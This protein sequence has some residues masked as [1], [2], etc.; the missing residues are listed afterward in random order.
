MFD[1]LFN[2]VFVDA[3]VRATIPI[4]LAALGGAIAERAGVFQIALE[5]SILVGAF[6]GIA[7]SYWTENAWVGLLFG[8]I[9]G[10]LVASVLAFGAVLRKADPIVLGIAINL[11]AV[12]VTGF[13]LTQ[14]FGVRGQFRSPRI[15]GLN[16]IEI[17]LL[18]EIPVIG[19]AFFA[20]TIVGYFAYLSVPAVWYF[21]FRTP[22]GLRLRG[23]GEDPGAAVSL[24]VNVTSYKVVATVFS[25][26]MAGIAGVQLSLSNVVLFT[27]NMSAGRGWIAV[28]AVI[29]G[30][31]H[32]YGV[33]AIV[34]LFGF[35][36]AL[37][38]RLQGEGLPSQVTQALPYVMALIA[39][40]VSRRHFAR[41]LDLSVSTER[42]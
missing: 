4:L 5:G 37:G 27:E 25:G 15:A 24:G 29:L 28:V 10:G 31:A 36:D 8:A 18:A 21:L 33:L 16:D 42:A 7:G 26:V 9:S 14:L 35:S 17:P 23:V 30:R 32:P 19:Q 11:L 22:V 12:G 2:A 39:L 38:I 40:A 41:M 3:I 1:S 34:T 6:A 20:T 13:L